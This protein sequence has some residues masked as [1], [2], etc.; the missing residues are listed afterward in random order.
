MGSI[1]TWLSFINTGA[2]SNADPTTFA[3]QNCKSEDCS[4]NMSNH[5]NDPQHQKIK[6]SARLGGSM[7]LWSRW[8]IR[9]ADLL[10][11]KK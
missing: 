6:K 3:V 7:F 2:P 4:L 1:I 11:T 8:R 9:T 10:I 5:F